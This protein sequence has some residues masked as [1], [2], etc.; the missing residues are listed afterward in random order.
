M[1][2][3]N[4]E[5]GAI[6]SKKTL[7]KIYVCI[8]EWDFQSNGKITQPKIAT[9]IGVHISTIKRYWSNF[10]VFVKE[11]NID[12]KDSLSD[13]NLDIVDCCYVDNF[14]LYINAP[15]IKKSA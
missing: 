15:V 2:I 4:K 11:L 13:N 10:K 6:S 3:V 1:K 14:K 8:E 5:L 7:D 9:L 12:Y